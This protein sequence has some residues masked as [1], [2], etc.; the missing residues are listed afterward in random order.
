MHTVYIYIYIFIYIYIYI[1][2]Y[3]YISVEG[4]YN[5]DFFSIGKWCGMTKKVFVKAHIKK[6]KT[7]LIF[8]FLLLV[9]DNHLN[10]SFK[11][12]FAAKP[13]LTF[14]VRN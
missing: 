14:Y 5:A 7:L 2:I 10:R 13:R 3:F 8:R 11:I 4:V 9:L 6:V 1:Y 12:K